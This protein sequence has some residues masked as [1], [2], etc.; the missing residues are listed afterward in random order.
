MLPKEDQTIF[1]C[2]AK[3]LMIKNILMEQNKKA[4]IY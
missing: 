3:S 1:I 2:G 4:Q